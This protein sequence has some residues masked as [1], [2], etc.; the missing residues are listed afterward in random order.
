MPSTVE[1]LILDALMARVNGIGIGYPVA[2][3]NVDYTPPADQKYLAVAFLPNRNQRVAITTTT[4]HR[5]GGLLQ[6][7]VYWPRGKGIAAPL[8][9]AGKVAE[10]FPA[11][12]ILAAG[13]VTIRVTQ[14][15]DVA[16]LLHEDQAV[17]VPVSIYWEA[18][19]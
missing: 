15:P 10:H 18:F 9:I 19:A 13:G 6:V 2:W 1:S 5:R 3:P 12:L 17:Q 14:A 16:G 7:S 8:D 11:D 4:P